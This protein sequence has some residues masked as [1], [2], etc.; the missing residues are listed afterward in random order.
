MPYS[1]PSLGL[2]LVPERGS[3]PPHPTPLFTGL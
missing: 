3:P 1:H 2:D